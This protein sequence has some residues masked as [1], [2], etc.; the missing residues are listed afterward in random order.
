M[1]AYELN[2]YN[3]SDIQ[4]YEQNFGLPSV[5]LQNRP[6]T[7]SMGSPTKTPPLTGRTPIL[8]WKR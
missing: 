7:A 8:A 5:N 1:A 3:L 4:T 6:G 2:G